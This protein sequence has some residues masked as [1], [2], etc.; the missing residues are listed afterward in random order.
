MKTK[1]VIGGRSE[2]GEGQQD[3]YE[4][5][6]GWRV[7]QQ[8]RVRDRGR[9]VEYALHVKEGFGRRSIVERVMRWL[10]ERL[11]GNLLLR[12]EYLKVYSR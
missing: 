4:A 6:T 8:E 7:K 2:Q 9:G 10:K 12:S 11:I 3:S 1:E 5:D